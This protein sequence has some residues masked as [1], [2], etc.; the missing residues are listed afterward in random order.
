[1]RIEYTVEIMDTAGQVSLEREYRSY[2]Q[3]AHA[4]IG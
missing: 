3:D 2:R 4:L 1:M